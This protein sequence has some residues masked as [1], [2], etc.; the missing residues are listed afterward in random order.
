MAAARI[1]AVFLAAV[2]PVA[3]AQESSTT[4]LTILVTDVIGDVVP[5]A[6]IKIDPSLPDAQSPLRTDSRGQA[7]LEL[8]VGGYTLSVS[9]RG[10][11]SWTRQI[12]VQGGSGQTIT[13]TLAVAS[14]GGPIVVADWDLRPELPLGSPEQVSLPLQPVSNLAPLQSHSAKRR[15]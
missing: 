13:A 4:Q 3:G 12:D 9:A 10:F 7:T 1:A 14:F 11:A 2:L 15:W 5:D 6:L 8:P